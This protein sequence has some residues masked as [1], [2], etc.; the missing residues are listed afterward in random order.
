MEEKRKQIRRAADKELMQRVQVLQAAVDRRG[1]AEE[2]EAA[3][4]RK[5]HAVRHNC[6][7]AIKMVLRHAAGGSNEWSVDAIRVEGRVLDLSVGG[8]SL[9]TKQPFDTGQELRLTIL[10]RDGTK[11][12]TNAMVRWVKSVPQKGG[13]ASGVQFVE[14]LEKDQQALNKFLRELSETSGL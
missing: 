9:F 2:Q 12:N 5:R 3:E 13:S 8:A 1:A 14:V 7:V 6:K 11:I 10:L 4:K